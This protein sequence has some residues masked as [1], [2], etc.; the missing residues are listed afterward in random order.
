VLRAE[1]DLLSLGMLLV[2]QCTVF[3]LDI[4]VRSVYGGIAKLQMDSR[5]L[6][7]SLEALTSHI[8]RLLK[9]ALRSL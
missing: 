8:I 4:L 7:T 2:L 5:E 1:A 3:G 6:A 9:D